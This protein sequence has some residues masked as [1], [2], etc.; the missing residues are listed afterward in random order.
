MG[1]LFVSNPAKK[2]SHKSSPG[3]LVANCGV[4]TLVLVSGEDALVRGF[5]LL[6]SFR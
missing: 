5:Q 6:F 3:S 2:P 4:A 1:G